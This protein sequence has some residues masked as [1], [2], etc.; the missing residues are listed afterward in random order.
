MSDWLGPRV[1]C[2]RPPCLGLVIGHVEL[3]GEVLELCRAHTLELAHA[4]LDLGFDIEI[5]GGRVA[6]ELEGRLDKRVV[7]A[8]ERRRVR[9]AMGR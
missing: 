7:E 4:L 3:G 9:Q 8:L 2:A 1:P 5:A 6:A